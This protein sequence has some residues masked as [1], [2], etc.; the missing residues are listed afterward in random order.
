MFKKS[1]GIVAVSFLVMAQAHAAT[2]PSHDMEGTIVDVVAGEIS[3]GIGDACIFGVETSGGKLVALVTD[4]D[5]CA[6]AEVERD[7]IGKKITV[8]VSAM[9]LIEDADS[10]RIFKSFD[11][12]YFYLYA[13]FDGIKNGIK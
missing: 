4:F 11:S 3:V 12:S 7:L 6:D 5:V 1:L 9:W 10:I 13:D 2:P 8:P